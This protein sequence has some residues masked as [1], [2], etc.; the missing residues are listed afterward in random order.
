MVQSFKHG[1]NYAYVDSET[2]RLVATY[3]NTAPNLALYELQGEVP[4]HTNIP[5]QPIENQLALFQ[6]WIA[7][8]HSV[9]TARLFTG[10]DGP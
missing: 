10:Y 9:E 6:A 7:A 1:N 5:E 8:G 2:G 3:G 4:V